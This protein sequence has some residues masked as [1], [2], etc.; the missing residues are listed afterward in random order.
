MISAVPYSPLYSAINTEYPPRD[1]QIMSA[2]LVWWRTYGRR[3]INF[4]STVLE[5]YFPAPQLFWTCLCRGTVH[6]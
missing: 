1:L 2:H 3:S 5:L 6:L 4:C